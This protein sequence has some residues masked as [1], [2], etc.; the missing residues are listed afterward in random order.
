M[1]ERQDMKASRFGLAFALCF[2]VGTAIS[3]QAETRRVTL[4]STDGAKSID[5]ELLRYDPGAGTI[6]YKRDGEMR[7]LTASVSAFAESTKA[8][9]D[10][11]YRDE[12]KV[13]AL[14]LSSKAKGERFEEKK[15]LFNY[16]RRKESYE[17]SVENR[18]DLELG[19][20]TARYEVL[21]TSYDKKAEESS[22]QAQAGTEYLE[23]M[24]E[25]GSETFSTSEVTITTGATCTSDCPDAPSAN[26]ERERIYGA[27]VTIL[28]E[29]GTV[30]TEYYTSNAVRVMAEKMEIAAV[31][32]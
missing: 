12:E 1:T 2:W 15:S 20:L 14:E 21:Y 25:G 30:L 13:R 28:D 17:I 6:V 22:L 16:E 19:A 23:P 31:E 7:H 3:L 5:V 24:G 27:K 18:S 26:Q 32:D 11:I 9:L 8:A 4:A 10:K 29:E